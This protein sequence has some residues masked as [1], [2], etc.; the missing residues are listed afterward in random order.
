MSRDIAAVMVT[1]DRSPQENYLTDTLRNLFRGGLVP[2][3]GAP[4]LLYIV[5]SNDGTWPLDVLREVSGREL[6]SE[7]EPKPLDEVV[8]SLRVV[9][10]TEGTVCANQNV[11]TALRTGAALERPWVLFMEDDIDVCANFF[12]SVGTWLDR[13][14]QEQYR[15]YPFGSAYSSNGSTVVVPQ[16]HFYGTQCFAIRA[17]DAKDLADFLEEKC[18]S[19]TQDGTAYDLLMSDWVGERYPAWKNFLAS[20]PS[21]VQHI[22]RESVIRPRPNV[23]KFQSWP[24]R[25]WSYA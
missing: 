20:S 15:V 25:D 2:E 18:Y 4:N 3:D 8:A 13:H 21:F 9:G 6:Q 22:G 11:A 16:G 17:S 5:D 7:G 14:A 10:H 24:G 12:Q 23:H 19:R 1:V